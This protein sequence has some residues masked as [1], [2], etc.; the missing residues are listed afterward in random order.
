MLER[1]LYPALDQAG[2]QWQKYMHGF[3]LFRRSCGKLL[4]E[5]THD[6]KMVQEYLRHSV[7]ST[8]M[9]EYVGSVDSGRGE[10]TELIAREL[11]LTLTVPQESNLVQ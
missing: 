9:D 6:V 11:G 7:I 1:A 4:Y 5:L 2:I 10:A 3:H 8:T